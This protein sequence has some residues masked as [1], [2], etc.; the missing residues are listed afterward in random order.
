MSDL[1]QAPSIGLFWI[2]V[3]QRKKW[4]IISMR[5]VLKVPF[6]NIRIFLYY[7][8]MEIFAKLKA[9][10]MQIHVFYAK[11]NGIPMCHEYW[12]W[13]SK[14]Q[15]DRLWVQGAQ[16]KRPRNVT[17]LDCTCTV[18]GFTNRL[19][20]VVQVTSQKPNCSRCFCSDVIYVSLPLYVF[21]NGDSKML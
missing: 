9:R 2:V 14:I 12:N 11:Q 21:T 3:S 19:G 5:L 4:I 16:H 8:K 20:A 10:H 6:G 1:H 18:S 17:G 13:L 15:S 7:V